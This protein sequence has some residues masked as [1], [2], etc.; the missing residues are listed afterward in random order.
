[1]ASTCLVMKNIWTLPTIP[2]KRKYI[3]LDMTVRSILPFR[4]VLVPDH[5]LSFLGLTGPLVLITLT[6]RFIGCGTMLEIILS[7][8]RTWMARLHYQYCQTEI[9][10]LLVW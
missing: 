4:M 2:A 3:L 10:R 9:M 1:M 8:M 7:C 5:L 6:T